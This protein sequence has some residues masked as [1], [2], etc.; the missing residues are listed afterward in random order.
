MEG[1]HPNRA[2]AKRHSRPARS[3]CAEKDSAL[4]EGLTAV[5]AMAPHFQAMSAVS[6]K[7]RRVWPRPLGNKTKNPWEQDNTREFYTERRRSTGS[8]AGGRHTSRSSCGAGGGGGR[9]GRGRRCWS[10]DGRSSRHEAVTESQ[11]P[12]ELERLVGPGRGMTF[13]TR[14]AP[15]AIDFL[16]VRGLSWGSCRVA[17]TKNIGQRIRRRSVGWRAGKR[18]GHNA[19]CSGGRTTKSTKH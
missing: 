3:L 12:T 15:R 4:P 16:N 8:S 7:N 9:G 10:H 2:H 13:A 1:I 18:G 14:S 11:G 19:H 5:R 6:R 17:A